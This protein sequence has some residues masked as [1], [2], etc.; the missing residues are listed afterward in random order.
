MNKFKKIIVAIV[1]FVPLIFF[2]G[3][4]CTGG[5]NSSSTTNDT[6]YS[7]RFITNNPIDFNYN[8]QEV[9]DGDTVVEPKRPSTFKQ[10]HEDG[11]YYIYSFVGWFQDSELTTPWMFSYE[12]HSDLDLFAKYSIRPE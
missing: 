7:V 8:T 2:S 4:N 1:L 5:N 11:K 3:C 12:V 6:V 9:K 10:A